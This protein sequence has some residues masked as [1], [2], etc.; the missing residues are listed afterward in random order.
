MECNEESKTMM[1][2]QDFKDKYIAKQRDLTSKSICP[3]FPRIV[4]IDI[5]NVC[6]YNC[7][8]CP[9]AKHH[10][11]VG[12]IDSEL[13]YRII[14]EAF[15]AGARELCLSSTGE[16]L[17]NPELENYIVFAK[18]LGYTYVFFNTNGY[19]LDEAR[20]AKLLKAGVDSIKVSVNSASKSYE[21][22]H[23]VD[24]FDRV[25]ENIKK[26]YE[27]RGQNENH[28]ALYVSY[29]AVR[30]T[31]QEVDIVRDILSPYV[32]EVVVM[33]AN[34]RGGDVCEEESGLYIGE[35]EY[36]YQ[37]PC[38]QLFNNVYV[39]A[40]GYMVICCQDFENLTVVADLKQENVREAWTNEKFTDFRIRYLR[41][42]LVGTLCQNCIYNTVEP[43]VPLSPEKAYYDI[44]YKKQQNMYDRIK[45]LKER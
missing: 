24:A 29:V 34:T 8:F 9:Q 16:P 13:C 42:E 31:L 4:K 21:L 30:Q 38:S 17:L 22:V 43:V 12:C 26:F 20:S 41:H 11:K 32:D 37:Y 40:E 33:N 44:S 5:C 19:L 39:T 35:D 14:R 25:V 27:L 2:K 23:G 45:Q 7:I 1:G 15:E 6:N 18:T 28:C 10:N 3:P 36:S